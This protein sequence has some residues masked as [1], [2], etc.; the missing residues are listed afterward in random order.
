MYLGTQYEPRDP[1]PD[2][3]RH[4]VQLGCNHICSTPSGPANTWTAASLS[5]HREKIESH[6]L[7]LD[8]IPLGHIGIGEDEAWRAIML[9]TSERDR[10]IEGVC[11]TIRQT[12]AAGIPAMKYYLHYLGVVSTGHVPGRGDS[13]NRTFVYADAPQQPLTE[14]G[15]VDADTMW[16]RIAYFLERVIPVATEY[17]VRMA[18]HP[19]DP[20]VPRPQGLR[21]VDRVMGSVDGLKRFVEIAA[22]PYHGL[23]FCQGT[24]CEMLQKPGEE[25][26]D[27]IRYFGQRDKIFNVHFRNI[28]GGFLDFVETFPDEG[29]ID[30]YE[31][32]RMYREVG[33][34]YMIMP[35]H[36]PK[37]A[38]PAPDLVAFGFALGYQKALLQAVDHL[39]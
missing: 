32:M 24:V 1:T 20:P 30:M 18:C 37:I 16:E 12:A 7:V 39:R 8:M 21:G 35:D 11:D 19:H 3:Y 23:N 14:A 36:V 9:G 10:A 22:S 38:G 25:I 29:D 17:K 26:G 34:K 28:R 2:Y 4:L 13:R 15:L 27:I 6:G 33:Y 31:A 5:Q